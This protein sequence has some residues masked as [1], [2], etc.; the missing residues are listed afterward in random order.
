MKSERFIPPEQK[1]DEMSFDLKEHGTDGE[2]S[3]QSQ[4][5]VLHSLA[6]CSV[7]GPLTVAYP[8]TLSG[9]EGPY[10]K[11]RDILLIY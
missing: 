3:L 1:T 8:I 2:H 7:T 11:V 9:F 10:H 5:A 4:Y 6:H